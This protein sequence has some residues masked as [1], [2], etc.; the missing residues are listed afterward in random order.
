M[1]IPNGWIFTLK[2]KDRMTIEVEQQ[3]LVVCRD[4]IY[5]D[6]EHCKWRKD[7]SPD[8]DDYCSVG[9]EA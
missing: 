1:H 8:P 5:Y 4:C 6:T 3:E 2:T 9:Q 7:E